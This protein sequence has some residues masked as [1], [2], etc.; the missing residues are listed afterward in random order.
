MRSARHGRTAGPRH[1][2]APG[3]LIIWLPI[4]NFFFLYLLNTYLMGAGETNFLLTFTFRQ[5][6]KE[7][8]VET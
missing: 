3:R 7:S 8:R 5:C 1:G 2:T 4:K 6:C